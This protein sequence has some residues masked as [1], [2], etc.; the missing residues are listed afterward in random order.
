MKQNPLLLAQYE[1]YVCH[2]LVGR[3]LLIFLYQVHEETG[4]N[5]AGQLDPKNVIELSIK[6]Q[7]ISLFIVP[8]VP[9]DYP[10]ETKTR[11][12]ISVRRFPAIIQL[13]PSHYDSENRMVQSGRPSYLEE[14]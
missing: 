4:Y 12:E 11:K 8:G 5:L 6:E 7:K 3:C 1:R 9:E 13:S 2:I 14:K 10:F